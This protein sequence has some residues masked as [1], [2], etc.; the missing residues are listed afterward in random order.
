[1][2]NKHKI[3]ERVENYLKN[4]S[5]SEYVEIPDFDLLPNDAYS[6]E[7]QCKIPVFKV[8]PLMPMFKDIKLKY[9]FAKYP[10]RQQLYLHLNYSYNHFSGSNGYRALLIFDQ[11]ECNQIS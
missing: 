2:K 6:E 10:E 3:R 4:V 11:Y 5:L 9:C 1:M 7:K 8:G